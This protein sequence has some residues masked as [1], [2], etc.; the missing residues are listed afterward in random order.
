MKH[1]SRETLFHTADKFYQSVF[2]EMNVAKVSIILEIH[3]LDDSRLGKSFFKHILKTLNRGIKVFI[4]LDGFSPLSKNLNQWIT[5][6][7]RRGGKISY[8]N[9]LPWKKLS[10]RNIFRLNQRS[11]KKVILIDK[12]VAYIGSYNIDTRQMSTKYGGEGWHDIGVRL[13]GGPIKK[14]INGFYDTWNHC[15]GIK[16]RFK[17]F[18]NTHSL[19]R[20]NHR[21]NWRSYFFNDLIE[22]IQSANNNVWITNPY[23]VPDFKLIK[24]LVKAK[25]NGIDVK[26]IIP[27]KSDLKLFPLINSIFYRDLIK[28]GVEVY[29]YK[30][31]IL[32][33][34]TIIIDDWYMLGSSNLNSRTQ[35]HDWEIDVIL[36]DTKNHKEMRQRFLSD[37]RNSNLLTY[38]YIL[39]K[40]KGLEFSFPF[41][42]VIK[43]FL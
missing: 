17:E 33:A 9:P 42:K 16:L 1:W 27:Q 14:I 41:L 21:C 24:A 10:L 19:V 18:P 12:K 11:H 23:F 5:L 36:K 29:E 25:K 34:K 4:I 8:F 43:Y 30:P 38:Q 6:Y 13:E 39:Y 7:K 26:I 20:L 37:M 15:R 22:R 28:Q 3:Y 32:H 35:K 31:R 2:N 40:F